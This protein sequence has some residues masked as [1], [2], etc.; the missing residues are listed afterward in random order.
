MSFGRVHA[1][2]EAIHIKPPLI[3]KGHGTFHDRAGRQALQPPRAGIQDPSHGAVGAQ[4]SD[5]ERFQDLFPLRN[6]QFGRVRRGGGA[7]V[8]SE[9]GNGKIRLV[10][11]GGDH[12][13]LRVINGPGRD[14]FIESP[15]ILHGSSAPP[16]DDQIRHLPPVGISDRRGDLT[17]GLLSLNAY[18][19]DYDLGKRPA[20]AED[21]D[22]IPD[23]RARGGGDDRDS[24]GHDGDRLFV[25]RG[26]QAFALQAGFELLERDIQVSDSVGLHLTYIE[27]I[28]A[29]SGI[30]R[31]LSGA[32]HAHAVFRPESDPFGVAAEHDAR[33][34]GLAVFESEIPVSRRID[35]IIGQ[36]TADQHTLQQRVQIYDI[37]DMRG[38]LA[39]RYGSGVR[40]GS[41]SFPDTDASRS[42]RKLPRMPLIKLTVSG[43]SNFLASST[44]SFTE[45]ASGISGM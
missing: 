42:L 19:K 41:F 45:A 39:D 9:I 31:N 17:G 40:H 4:L 10:P 38:E 33:E 29:V 7:A 11:H 23:S 1:F 6:G 16:G 2:R 37:P 14:L 25:F 26:E 22:D 18:R 8:G 5:R 36:L 43:S 35:L 30:Y 34:S 12:G 21:P 28:F 3:D 32:E 24:R 13:Y 44:A 27:L 15:K 20:L